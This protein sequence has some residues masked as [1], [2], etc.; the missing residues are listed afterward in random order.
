MNKP[1]FATP[2]L[3]F[4]FPSKTYEFIFCSCLL[5]TCSADPILFDFSIVVDINSILQRIQI[6]KILVV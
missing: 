2:Y 5:H 6:V 3:S 1:Y 4:R